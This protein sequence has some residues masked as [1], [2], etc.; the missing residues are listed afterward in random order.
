[1][2]RAAANDSQRHGLPWSSARPKVEQ[3]WSD[4]VTVI[5]LNLPLVVTL[6]T[7][8]VQF[9]MMTTVFFPRRLWR[10]KKVFQET[11]QDSRGWKELLFHPERVDQNHK[12]NWSELGGEYTG[13]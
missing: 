3:T 1:M 11:N 8:S 7:G 10:N 6:V 9:L 5:I 2:T 4:L 13:R 12:E